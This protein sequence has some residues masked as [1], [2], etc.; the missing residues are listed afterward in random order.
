MTIQEMYESIGSDYQT[1]LGR[2][3]KDSL[4]QKLV[5]KYPMDP[6]YQ[7]LADSVEQQDYE[8]MFRA[9][10]TLKGVALNLGFSQLAEV[11]TKMTESLRAGDHDHVAEEFAQVKDAQEKLLSAI[12]QLDA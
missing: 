9:V 1:V 6:N 3:V 7:L 8:V 5:M 4:V 12:S 11:S 10:H 2:L